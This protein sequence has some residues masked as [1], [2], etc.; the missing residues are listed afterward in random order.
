[1]SIN[2]EAASALRARIILGEPEEYTIK[3][4]ALTTADKAEIICV[5]HRT[6]ERTRTKRR[7]TINESPAAH[8]IYESSA[9]D[10][11]TKAELE[12]LDR[13]LAEFPTS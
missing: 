8:M 4:H 7:V 10:V 11:P 2:G 9:W 12:W 3:G 5:V 6:F 13:A 1:M